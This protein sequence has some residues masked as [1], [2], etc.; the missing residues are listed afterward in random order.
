MSDF[1]NSTSNHNG[2]RSGFFP[3]L[4]SKHKGDSSVSNPSNIAKPSKLI[5]LPMLGNDPVNTIPEEN[6]GQLI[7][8]TSNCQFPEPYGVSTLSQVASNG[9]AVLGLKKKFSGNMMFPSIATNK[10]SIS[11]PLP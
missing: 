10:E 2:K 5:A 3:N 7:P 11:G 1:S 4:R 8:S 6:V 9:A